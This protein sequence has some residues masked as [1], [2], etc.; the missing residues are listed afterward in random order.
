[1]DEFR[2]EKWGKRHERNRELVRRHYGPN[3]PEP[4]PST[5]IAELLGIR[6]SRVIQIAC[7]LRIRGHKAQAKNTKENCDFIRENYGKMPVREIAKNLGM[8]HETVYKYARRMLSPEPEPETRRVQQKK[9]AHDDLMQ[10][11]E[12]VA[13][14][15]RYAAIIANGGRLFETAPTSQ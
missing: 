9:T 12:R 6:K 7:K 2:M 1:M 4:L 14:I 11:D 15:E 10:D 8:C 3:A 13:R 5:K